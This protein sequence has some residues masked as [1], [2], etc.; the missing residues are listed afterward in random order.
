MDLVSIPRN[1]I[2]NGAV[3]GFFAG[4][5]GRQV[6]YARWPATVPER[7][8]TVCVF[9]GRSEYIEKYFETIAE[10]RRRGCAVATMDWRGQ[11]GSERLLKNRNKGHV[12]D[13][14]DFDR[15][16]AIFMRDIVLPDMPPPYFALAHSMGGNILLRSARHKDCWFERMVLVAPMIRLASRW[17]STS[18]AAA[19]SE[20]ATFFGLGD[21]YVPGGRNTPLEV[22]GQA[23]GMLTSDLER[24]ARN[25]A[26]LTAAPELGLGSPTIG[27]VRA[28]IAS[29]KLINDFAFPTSVHVPVLMLA[30]GN[31]R[32]VSSTAIE[33]LAL[34]LKAGSQVVIRGACHEILQ[35]RDDVR[36]QFWAAFD[37]YVPGERG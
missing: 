17:M 27:W 12:E 13:F 23:A 36:E 35:E 16:L 34:Q 25:K 4:H 21:L 8:G 31:D 14:S 5:D 33:E 20:I 11:G 29:M 22:R 9:G 6:R 15:D 3:S 24:L 30:A 32:I 7:R 18:T 2:P 1:P 28:A 37:A 10:L 19:A 26:I